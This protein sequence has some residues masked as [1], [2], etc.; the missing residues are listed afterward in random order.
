MADGAAPGGAHTAPE[1]PGAL[2]RLRGVRGAHTASWASGAFIRLRGASGGVQM[3]PGASDRGA[4]WGAE[5]R[6]VP[7]YLTPSQLATA[8]RQGTQPHE[9]ASRKVCRSVPAAAPG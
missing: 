8:P 6:R 3:A 2:T 7:R 9:T 5:R 1:R 4:G